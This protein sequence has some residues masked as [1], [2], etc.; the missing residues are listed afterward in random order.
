MMTYKKSFNYNIIYISGYS[1]LTGT[2]ANLTNV[3]CMS[4]AL[5]KK[6]NNLFLIL[7]VLFQT[8]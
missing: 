2:Q 4:D 3:L 7:F 5:D 8:F 1:I 6:I